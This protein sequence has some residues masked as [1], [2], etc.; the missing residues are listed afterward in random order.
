MQSLNGNRE[1]ARKSRKIISSLWGV[2]GDCDGDDCD[3]DD[4]DDDAYTCLSSRCR[5]HFLSGGLLA[6]GTERQG[7]CCTGKGTEDDTGYDR[8]AK[9]ITNRLIHIAHA[10]PTLLPGPLPPLQAVHSVERVEKSNL[11]SSTARRIIINHAR[12]AR[13]VLLVKWGGGMR[14]SASV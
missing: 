2:A 7:S 9:L 3:D 13:S 12:K 6:A 8:R 14:D 11:S 5:P 10:R 1:F 4:G